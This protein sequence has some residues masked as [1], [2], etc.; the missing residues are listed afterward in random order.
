MSSRLSSL[1]AMNSPGDE[2]QRALAFM[3]EVDEGAAT[4]VRA[5]S[6]GTVLVTP[7]LPRVWDASHFRVEDPGAADGER[8][9]AETVEA[10]GA[11]GLLHAAVVGADEKVASR[12]RPGLLG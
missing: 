1:R 8:V 4:D 5:W 9:A 2:F 3:A 11:A 10:A 12:L 7:E 6:L